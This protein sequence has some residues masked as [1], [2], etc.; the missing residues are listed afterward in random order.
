MKTVCN[1]SGK[2]PRDDPR[3][4]HRIGQR[5][6]YCSDVYQLCKPNQ[7]AFVER[8]NRSLRDDVLNANL[9]NSEDQAQEAVDDCIQDYDKFRSHESP[10]D[11]AHIEF[12]P[13]KFVKEI[14]SI[15]LST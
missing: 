8:F 6:R 5:A 15:E 4:V 13:M 3:E 1:S 11:V 12:V 7:N 9:F 10:G 14:A 2:R